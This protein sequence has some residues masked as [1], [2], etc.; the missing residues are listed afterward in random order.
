MSKDVIYNV[1]FVQP[2]GFS[3]SQFRKLDQLYCRAASVKTLTYR[4]VDCDFDEGVARYTYYKS[5]QFAPYLQFVIRK[6]G[7][8]NT[9]FEVYLEGKGCVIK[10]G[11]FDKA[12]DVLAQHID[13]LSGD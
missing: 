7:P 4:T 11:L 5:A 12:Y 13:A 1:S 6:V 9:L 10:S 8:R 2:A 3:P